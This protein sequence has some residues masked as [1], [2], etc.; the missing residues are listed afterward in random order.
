MYRSDYRSNQAYL[1]KLFFFPFRQIFKV[2]DE[3]A[4]VSY[5]C[6]QTVTDV[7]ILS[8]QVNT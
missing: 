6:E 5:N 7:R 2:I 1:T 3:N 8:P 4:K